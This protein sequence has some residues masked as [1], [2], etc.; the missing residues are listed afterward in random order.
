MKETFTEIHIKI[1]EKELD[2]WFHV[3]DNLGDF[4]HIE[5][6]ESRREKIQYVYERIGAYYQMVYYHIEDLK[7]GVE[8]IHANN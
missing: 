2:R 3:L 7:E 8:A 5:D 1:M 6:E 4:F